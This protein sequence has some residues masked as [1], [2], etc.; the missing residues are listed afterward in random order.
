MKS[1]KILVSAVLIPALLVASG[2]GASD[3]V[4]KLL[5]K[6]RFGPARI[7]FTDGTQATGVVNRVTTQFLSLSEPNTC[8][9]VALAQIAS[10]KWFPSPD[11][12]LGLGYLALMVVSSPIW[13]PWSIAYDLGHRDENSPLDGS[14]ESATMSPAGKIR[15]IEVDYRN[16]LVQRSIDVDKGRY[17]VIGQELHLAYDGNRLVETIP[18]EFDCDSLVLGGHKL[19]TRNST[20]RAQA[21]IV[22]RWL[23]DGDRYSFWE[24]AASGA[25]EKRIAESHVEGQIAKIKGGVRVKWLGSDA[26]PVEDWGVRTKGH[27][28]LI[29]AG[30]ST[31]EYV[32]AADQQ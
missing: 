26:K 11:D 19:S 8:R 30:G 14:W 17:E 29:T 20:N 10:I 31:T 1:A 3:S 32:H 24:F 9:N 5:R 21:P 6:P 4:Q 28:L 25:F 13:I 27:Y 18:I 16:V 22:G 23:P 15:R 2:G 12:S 7:D